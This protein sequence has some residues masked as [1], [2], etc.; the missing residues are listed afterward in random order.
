MKEKYYLNKNDLPVIPT[1]HDCVI[2]KIRL[3]GKNLIL[4]FEN[5][6]SVHDSVRCPKPEAKSLIMTFHLLGD[7]CDISLLQR[8]RHPFNRVLHRP[9]V[10]KEIDIDKDIN[11]LTSLTSSSLEYLYHY[12][13]YCSIIL[14]LWSMGSIILDIPADY[15]ELEWIIS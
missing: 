5:D 1:P 8:K 4:I 10:Y 11:K 15:V 9:G 14:K 12:V 2:N 6:I 13:G 3:E 7:I